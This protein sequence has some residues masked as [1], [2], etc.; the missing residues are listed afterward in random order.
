MPALEPARIVVD[1]ES[2]NIDVGQPVTEPLLWCEVDAL[3][4]EERHPSDTTTE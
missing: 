3:I 1:M 2:A 4:H